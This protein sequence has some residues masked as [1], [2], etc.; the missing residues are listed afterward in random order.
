[1]AKCRHCGKEFTPKTI[2]QKTCGNL[3]C[4]WGGNTNFILGRKR[5]QKEKSVWHC[6]VCGVEVGSN[7]KYC[8]DHKPFL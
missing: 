6:K 3:N 2:K 7:C 8:L 4:V 5:K 1:M